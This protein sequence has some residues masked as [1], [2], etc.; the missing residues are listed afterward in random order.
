MT[1]TFQLESF[2]NTVMELKTLIGGHYDQLSL[3]KAKGFPLAPQW[4]VY[5]DRENR[6][7]LLFMTMRVDGKLVG[8]YIGMIAPGF[9]YETCLTSIQDI[10]YIQPEFRGPGQGIRLLTA[11]ENEHRRRRVQLSFLGSKVHDDCSPLFERMKY[12]L[13]EKTYCKWLGAGN[14]SGN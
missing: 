4:K 7:E 13:V 9:H 2:R 6:D 12:E 14:D 1:T 3:H 8:Y 10:F 5:F 11:V